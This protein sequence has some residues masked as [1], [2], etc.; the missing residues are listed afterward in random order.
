MM[1]RRLIAALFFVLLAGGGAVGRA[2]DD[3]VPDAATL[4]ARMAAAIGPDNDNYRETVVGT[5]AS[6]DIVI[7][8]AKRGADSLTTETSGNVRTTSG[9]FAGNVW[10]QNENG[11]T[12]ADTPDPGE[13]ARAKVTTTVEHVSSP[14]DAY[15]LSVLDEDGFGHRL[16]VDPVSYLV[17]RRENIDVVD[18]SI[19]TNGPYK[20]YGSQ[21]MPASWTID[22]PA[23]KSST[24]YV[25][26]SFVVGAATAAD[27]AVPS[28]R[29][30]VTFPSGVSS[31]DLHA[32]FSETATND[33]SPIT[34]PV[35]IG[36]QRIYFLL[37]TGSAGFLIDQNV[38][39]SLGLERVGSS[40]TVG[41]ARTNV[42]EVLIPAM[43]VGG[44]RMDNIFA[45]TLPFGSGRTPQDPA[46]L[47]GFDFL[48]ELIVNVDYANHHVTV[49]DPRTFV[50]PAGPHVNAIPIRLGDRVPV[51]SMNVGG[52]TAE[53]MVV[54]TGSYDS[55]LLFGYFT[56]RHAAVLRERPSADI[57][58][59]IDPTPRFGFT[60]GIGGEAAIH[61]TTVPFIHLGHYSFRD[62]TVDV[63][64]GRRGFPWNFDGLLGRQVLHVFD[65]VFDYE[66][67]VIYLWPKATGP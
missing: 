18:R 33:V 11:V 15:V 30:L 36:N 62:V 35:T 47:I 32:T 10:H 1:R 9:V 41:A 31:I 52:A 19:V 26:T 64:N 20:R 14:M 2:A 45:D 46:G 55:L 25:R 13:A 28:V 38:A 54:D 16:F 57:L 51:I 37:D 42:G 8:D 23:D 4:Q 7:T 21:L 50:P 44:V 17:R 49:S 65:L 67:G 12:Y 22:D 5:N 48:A 56:R 60:E 6:G 29:Q 63:I 24:S 3:G 27:V 34:I 58:Q 59:S 66:D 53:R 61:H 43:D 40:S 39:A